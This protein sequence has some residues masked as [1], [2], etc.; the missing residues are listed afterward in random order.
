MDS[1]FWCVLIE[2][3]SLRNVG[4]HWIM[5]KA[6]SDADIYLVTSSNVLKS[7]IMDSKFWCVL[8]EDDVSSKNFSAHWI[9]AK[10]MSNVS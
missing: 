6:I 2:N 8:I 5:A 1:K 3:V 7:Q 9:I 10:V 4:T